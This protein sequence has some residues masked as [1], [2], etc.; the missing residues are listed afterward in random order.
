MDWSQIAQVLMMER[1]SPYV[2]GAGI[3]VLSWLAFLLSNK[4]LGCS[5]AFAKTAGMVERLLAGAERS[6]RRRYWQVVSPRIDWQWMLVFGV[7]IGAFLSA[8][9]S[10]IFGARWVPERWA[11]VFGTG[12]SPRLVVAFIGGVLMGLG[13]RWADG[14]TSGH[15][16]SGTLQLALSGWIAAI[17]FFISGIAAAMLI[18]HVLGA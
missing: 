9:L 6:S 3:G 16:I 13:A 11:E 15:G 17:C 1:W 7:V 2:V 4:P 14:C 12:V 18:Y 10:G 8:Q 5:T